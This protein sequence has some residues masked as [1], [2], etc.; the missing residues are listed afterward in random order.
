MSK[1]V[2]AHAICMGCAAYSHSL[3]CKKTERDV[4]S[5]ALMKY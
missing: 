4:K 1:Q 5:K 2:G 3:T